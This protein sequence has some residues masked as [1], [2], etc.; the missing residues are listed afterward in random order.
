MP[1]RSL[2][3]QAQATDTASGQWTRLDLNPDALL[4]E[5]GAAPDMQFEEL[6]DA[7][8]AVS[9]QA[10]KH[11]ASHQVLTCSCAAICTSLL[12]ARHKHALAKHLVHYITARA[13]GAAR[14]CSLSVNSISCCQDPSR[15]CRMQSLGGRPNLE[16]GQRRHAGPSSM[17]T[18]RSVRQLSCVSSTV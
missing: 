8:Q 11:D 4:E 9:R 16:R 14:K 7:P 6:K 1:V 13:T 3:C 12:Q 10:A 5:E 17:D 18:R 15:L 2:H